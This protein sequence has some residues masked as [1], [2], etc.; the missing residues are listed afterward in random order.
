MSGNHIIIESDLEG[1]VSSSSKRGM[2]SKSHSFP[3][4]N[5]DSESRVI[6]LSEDSKMEESSRKPVSRKALTMNT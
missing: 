6:I 3:S 2:K 4:T 1:S 5:G